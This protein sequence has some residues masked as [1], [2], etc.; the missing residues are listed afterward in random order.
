M[1]VHSHGPLKDVLPAFID[2]GADILH[3]L[4]APPMGDVTPKMAKEAFRDKVCIEGNIQIGDMYEKR[5][6]E[7]RAMVTA[8]IEDTF[9]DR[10]GLI[11]CPTASPYV[12][13]M[14]QQCHDNYAALV[15]VVTH[16]Q[17]D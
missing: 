6:E 13:E 16:W 15:D 3:P 12:P 17:A 10:K 5:P 14:S 11:V 1:H 8:L 2:L 9:D 4:E 7:I